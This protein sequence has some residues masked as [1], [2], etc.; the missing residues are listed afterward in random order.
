MEQSN[1]SFRPIEDDPILGKYLKHYSSHRMLL[2]VLGGV[3]YFAVFVVL[4]IAT[5]GVVSTVTDIIVP[6]LYTVAALMILWTLA[7]Y[8]NREV[9][10][11][12]YGF[13]YKQGSVV[14]TFSYYQIKSFVLN[15][16]RIRYFGV[17]PF[18]Q[19][20]CV[21]TSEAGDI[22]T[23][24]NVYKDVPKLIDTLEKLITE[25]RLP[26]T[27]AI[28]E[29]GQTANFGDALGINKQG[30]LDLASNETLAWNSYGGYQLDGKTLTIQAHPN[31]LWKT[32][33]VSTFANLR[34][35]VTLMKERKI[36][37]EDV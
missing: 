2:L 3:A 4:T 8:W 9:I 34:L 19:Y 20:R 21:M 22:M 29:Q 18:V 17:F 10:L 36:V 26:I 23:L 16:E 7:H 28:L 32:Y 33:P 15:I 12:Q 13:S 14:A 25:L 1:N 31:T 30:I 11:F 35:F 24:N 5:L 6:I 37:H 27:N